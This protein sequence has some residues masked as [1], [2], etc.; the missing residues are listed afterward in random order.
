MDS[1]DKHLDE[2][3]DIRIMMENSRVYNS[4][5][6]L[7]GL[8]AGIIAILA[9]LISYIVTDS[10]IKG[11]GDMAYNSPAQNFLIAVYFIVVV[12]SLI[13]AFSTIFYLNSRKAKF[14]SQNFIDIT[15]RRMF[16]NLFI[17]LVAGVVFCIMLVSKELYLLI[18]PCM[19]IFYGLAM[20]NAS[21]YTLDEIR[22]LGLVELLIGL[23]AVFFSEYGLWFWLLGF[24]IVNIIYGAYVYYS[25]ERISG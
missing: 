9:Y 11:Q 24:G 7:S 8:P 21:K 4:L 3:E 13:V 25:Y 16:F 20:V 10:F 6:G 12:I 2:L 18:A 5:S 23:V 14:L 15:M 22:Y 1:I 17:P 19:L